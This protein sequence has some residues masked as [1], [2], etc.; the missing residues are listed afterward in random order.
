MRAAGSGGGD[1]Q[2]V[3]VS[4]LRDDLVGGGDIGARAKRRGSAQGD[5]VWRPTCRAQVIGDTVHRVVE[6]IHGERS[7]IPA[8]SAQNDIEELVSFR[9]RRWVAV[10]SQDTAEAGP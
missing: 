2:D 10:E 8:L 7:E 9:R 1:N 3:I 4:K 6:V 5:D